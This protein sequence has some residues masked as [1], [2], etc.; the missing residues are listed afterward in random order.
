VYIPLIQVATRLN[1]SPRSVKN[2]VS[3]GIIQPVNPD[4]YRRDGGY[5]FLEEDVKKL[6]QQQLNKL[7]LR[8][9]AALIGITPQYL[10]QLA[11]SK[12]KWIDSEVTTEGK[13][14]RRWFK[15]E[16]CRLLMQK[17]ANKELNSTIR[18]GRKLNPYKNEI[19]LFEPH[20]FD[21]QM[22]L[23]INTDPLQVI[24]STGEL[25]NADK[26]K[27]VSLPWP[28]SKYQVKKGT[29][30]ISFAIP[31]RPEHPL[32]RTLYRMI[33]S[34]GPK[35]TKIYETSEGNYFVRCRQG[36]IR[37]TEEDYKII[38]KNTLNGQSEFDGQY[39]TLTT[40][41]VAKL[42]NLHAGY[43]TEITHLSGREKT[44]FDE[45]LNKVI[46]IGLKHYV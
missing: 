1:I 45:M 3:Q 13:Q 22:L 5:K 20:Q 19:R 2:M 33:E 9:A 37:G 42:V 34:L 41:A 31:R 28:E 21:G 38:S 29:V 25:T 40:N 14:K 15:E 39:I 18:Y 17:M 4:T 10:N 35:N 16:D 26:E 46:S 12:E 7:S 30:E 44:D 23:V 6:I 8:K 24:D 27:I 36:K 11:K 32:Y 43:I